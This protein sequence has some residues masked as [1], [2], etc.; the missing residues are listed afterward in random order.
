MTTLAGADAGW[1]DEGR[2]VRIALEGGFWSRVRVA[3]KALARLM[4]NPDDTVQVFFL[5]IALNGPRLPGIVGRIAVDPGGLA[6]LAERPTID[7]RTVDFRR[8]RALPATTLGG[9]YARYLDE[10]HLDPD[11][12]QPPPGL[13]PVP[14]WVAQ[15][16]RQ[17]HD[18]WHVLTGYAPDVPGELALQAFTYGQ[19]RVPSAWL[20]AV[21]GTL[22]KSPRSAPAVLRGFQRGAAAVFLPVVR[23]EDLWD[24]DLAEV[25]T[26]LS[27]APEGARSAPRMS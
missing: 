8:L 3:G 10:N 20:I 1:M 16:V 26:L 5:G 24:R 23:F 18:I 4:R 14:R 19:L 25:R 15:R 17:T 6:L 9:A 22:L 27:I 11:L 7:S 2:A 13:P 12:F 21:F